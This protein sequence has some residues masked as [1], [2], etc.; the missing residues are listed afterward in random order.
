M[1]FPCHL[2]VGGHTIKVVLEDLK[3]D[4]GVFSPE[5]NTI[6]IDKSLPE[7][8]RKVTLLHEILHV[9]NSEFGKGTPHIFI[10]SLA[11]QMYQVLHDNRLRF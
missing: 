4:F 10:E 1:K 3:N 8:Q 11:Q 9:L 7:N 6:T 5:T 2:K